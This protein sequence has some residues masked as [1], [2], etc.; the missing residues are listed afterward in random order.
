MLAQQKRNIKGFSLIELLVVVALIGVVAGVGFP[1]FSK[2][3]KDREIRSQHEKIG[4]YLTSAVSHVER[5][6]YPYIQIK[7]SIVSKENTVMVRG[8]PQEKFS[9]LLNQ[10]TDLVCSAD[11]FSNTNGGIVLLNETLS[12]KI[13]IFP[14]VDSTPS[15][16]SICFS[17][18]GK[19]FKKTGNA[20]GVGPVN[21]ESLTTPS[22]N[23]IVICSSGSTCN[24]TTPAL[25]K[26][27]Y[28]IKYS[29]F[30]LIEKYKWSEVNGKW[31]SR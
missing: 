2:W 10:G 22:Y 20:D 25:D 7:F 21:F 17:K 12:D 30:G 19:Y 6:S 4:T 16:F 14:P 23:Y 3:S 5:G 1:Q 24:P 28:G 8:L 31:N 26:F 27:T 9:F 29:R 11:N 18:G 13:E 15:S